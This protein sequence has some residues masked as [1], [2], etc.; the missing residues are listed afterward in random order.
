MINV[1]AR[2]TALSDVNGRIDYISSE[3]KQEH[4]VATYTCVDAAFWL[5][6]SAHCQKQAKEAG[7]KKA[8]EGREWHGALPNEYAE[9]YQGREEELAKELSELLKS[10]TG[11]ENIVALHWNQSMTNFHFHCVCSENKEVNEIVYGAELTR[12]TYYNAKGKRA[13]KK[14]CTD[15]AGNLLPGC[16]LYKK[17]D[18]IETIKRFGAKEDLRHYTVNEA[19]KEALAKKFNEDLNENRFQKFVNDGIHVAMQKVGKYTPEP[20]K[21]EIEAKNEV[22]RAYNRVAD[23]LLQTAALVDEKQVE[24]TVDEL[25]KVRKSIKEH[26]GTNRWLKALK[27][28]LEYLKTQLNGLRGFVMHSHSL[29]L[30]EKIK[31]AKNMTQTSNS[32]QRRSIRNRER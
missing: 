6:L 5:D 18:R 21:S 10:I 29:T 16:K 7:H 32:E 11:T 9:M 13:S 22:T 14:E 15:E 19:I 3:K 27:H 4:L 24:M 23:E 17:G 25:K 8:C 28:Y 1:Y 26:K 30:E 12:N 31:S 2:P 20:I